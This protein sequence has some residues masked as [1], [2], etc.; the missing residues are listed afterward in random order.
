MQ[1]SKDWF[2]F[3]KLKINKNKGLVSLINNERYTFNDVN[4]LVNEIAEQKIGKNNA[5]KAYNNL[6]DKAEKISELRSTPRRQKI[7]EIFNY[8]GELFNGATSEE[9]VSRGEGL[10][11]NARNELYTNWVKEQ[12]LR[13]QDCSE[14][15]AEKILKDLKNLADVSD[16]DEFSKELKEYAELLN[17]N[18]FKEITSKQNN[19][20]RLFNLLNNG[21]NIKTTEK[22]TNKKT[23][24]IIIIKTTK[25]FK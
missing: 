22:A 19:F 13:K 11:T 17:S 5:I 18:I 14:H 23:S 6:L 15:N 1:L 4:K 10:N 9:S 20:L 16:F 8:L 2:N 3:I 12:A 24:T 21:N 7:S 25:K